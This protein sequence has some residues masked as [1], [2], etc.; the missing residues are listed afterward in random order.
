M[1]FRLTARNAINISEHAHIDDLIERDIV[2]EVQPMGQT[3]ALYIVR[4]G[5]DPPL[6]RREVLERSSSLTVRWSQRLMLDPYIVALNECRIVITVYRLPEMI[7]LYFRSLSRH[8]LPCISAAELATTLNPRAT[9]CDVG[10][11]QPTTAD[12]RPWTQSQFI[13]VDCQIQRTSTMR[14]FPSCAYSF[15]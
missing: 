5:F 13:Y 11:R 14:L 2:G 15:M 9:L 3:P 4:R 6:R 12:G 10:R 8:K 7:T 1:N